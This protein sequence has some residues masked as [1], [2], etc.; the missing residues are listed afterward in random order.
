M[1]FIKMQSNTKNCLVTMPMNK[2]S[3]SLFSKIERGFFVYP[4]TF[5][6]LSKNIRKSSKFISFL[7]H[8]SPDAMLT[9]TFLLKHFFG[10]KRKEK[11]TNFNHFYARLWRFGLKDWKMW[12]TFHLRKVFY[13][14][15]LKRL[16]NKN[17]TAFRKFIRSQI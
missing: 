15:T 16:N 4:A 17:R 11:K 5:F 7:M 1:F 14:I 8:H 6:A 10:R 9:L 12:H 2:I 13:L 3:F